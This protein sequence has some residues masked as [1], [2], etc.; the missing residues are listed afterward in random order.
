MIVS[1]L[2]HPVSQK[3]K[4]TTI[5]CKNINLFYSKGTKSLRGLTDRQID[6]EREGGEGREA[7]ILDTRLRQTCSY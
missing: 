1:I 2:R 7:A 5:I 3:G 6:R 4:T